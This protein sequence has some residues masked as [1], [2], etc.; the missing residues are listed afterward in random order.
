MNLSPLTI[1][2]FNGS[3]I[4]N[5]EVSQD[6]R[7]DLGC[8]GIQKEAF[9]SLNG[10]KSADNIGR[11]GRSADER[12][13]V[14]KKERPS[15][16]I[17]LAKTCG[18]N[19]VSHSNFGGSAT[20]HARKDD[21]TNVEFRYQTCCGCRCRN[22][23]PLREDH[24]NRYSPQRTNMA[25]THACLNDPPISSQLGNQL[26]IFFLHCVHQSNCHL[27]FLFSLLLEIE[28]VECLFAVLLI[29]ENRGLGLEFSEANITSTLQRP[30]GSGQV[31]SSRRYRLKD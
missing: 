23:T 18:D 7:V 21:F 1:L 9:R 25:T 28:W 30:L 3:W 5:P 16:H 4:D 29:F 13:F 12:D 14:P 24:D 27:R 2:T 11:K 17:V 22:F 19:D 26:G 15:I 20:R 31:E 10:V 8:K 6:A